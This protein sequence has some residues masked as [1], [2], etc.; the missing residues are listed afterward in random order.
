RRSS[1]LL[2]AFHA[3]GRRPGPRDHESI[4]QP[5][6]GVGRHPAHP[7]QTQVQMCQRAPHRQLLT[8]MALEAALLNARAVRPARTRRTHAVLAQ[9]GCECKT[10]AMGVSVLDR[11]MFSEA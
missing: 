11:E 4:L 2:R 1:D 8:T 9:K 10:A 6:T 7:R 5:G 3:G